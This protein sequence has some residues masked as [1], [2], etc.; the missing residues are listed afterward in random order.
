MNCRRA[1]KLVF[2]FLDGLSDDTKR[3]ALEKHL[4]GCSECESLASGLARSMDLLHRAPTENP[5]ENFGW[6]VRLKLNQER[7]AIHERT[8][9]QGSLLRMWNLRYAT[10]A[11]AAF[12]VV[13]A[14][15]VFAFTSGVISFDANSPRTGPDPEIAGKVPEDS[16]AVDEGRRADRQ[17]T[18]QFLTDL[19]RRNIRTVSG[20][21]GANGPAVAIPP[22]IE[23]FQSP[24]IT[25]LD[26]IV[27]VE[28][29]ALSP[30]AQAKYLQERIRLL[31]RHL[32][33]CETVKKK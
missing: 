29:E 7:N 11:V 31:Q 23:E 21:N 28:T 4:A 6:K 24:F 10:G 16:G 17:S 2:E 26:S 25:D 22:V 1:R 27:R 18:E 8:M 32:E 30:D 14:V 13:V 12:V 20:P 33:R 19:E 15:G 5:S 9:S 3:A